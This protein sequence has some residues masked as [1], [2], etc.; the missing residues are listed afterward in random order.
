MTP[1]D[2]HARITTLFHDALEQPAAERL[3]WLERTCPDTDLRTAVTAMLAAHGGDDGF[4][5]Q[6]FL[7]RTETGA[8]TE[9]PPDVRIQG[10]PIGP[11][12]IEER[13]G[14]GGMGVVYRASRADGLYERTV[15]LKL[16]APGTILASG[17]P[18]ARRLAAERQIL[19][20][21]EH[22]GIARL[23]DG[24]VTE[25]GLPY[26]ALELVDGEPITDYA[27]RHDLNAAQRVDLFAQA[28][29]A[30]AYA[31]RNLV[32]HR[33]L[34]P[35]HILIAE[36]AVGREAI[37]KLLDFGVSALL[38][39][40]TGD[41]LT[42]PT[43][44]RALTPS[45]A[46]PEQV[47]GEPVTTA[48]D[49]YALGV[50]LYELLT[51]QRPYDLSGKTAS[52]VERLVAEV[53]PP[54][55]STVASPERARTLRGDLDTIVMKALAKEPERRYA[56]AEALAL[57]L[58][59]HLRGLPVE[60][61]PATARY[62]LSR[63]VRRHRVGVAATAAVVL[64]TATLIGFYTARLAAERD[65]TA[66]ALLRAEGTLAF[67]EETILSGDPQQGDF[68]APLSAVL[69]SAAARVEAIEDPAVAAAVGLALATVYIGRGLPEPA[70][71]HARE[72]FAFYD[73]EEEETGIPTTERGQALN[74]IA[75]AIRDQRRLEDALP[76]HAQAIAHLRRVEDGAFGLS[77]A[78]NNYGATLFK[79]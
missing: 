24:G 5:D 36:N 69:D 51:G 48:A 3:A 58:R 12:R 77:L 70:E 17:E 25:E 34:K 27:D 56:S 62:R 4:L 13:L 35:A 71:Q 38:G 53:E 52:E 45:Y 21:L 65:R 22:P 79:L 28:C 61:R 46:A 33:D 75:T 9:A 42:L 6:P 78:L 44:P 39:D 16:L 19:A 47:R 49:V 72:A 64:V 68:D 60:A 54:L 63:F 11:W 40:P 43:V 2:R 31:H 26:L 8:T 14:A 1:T 41:G 37:V 15:A 29:D 23:Y 67:L 18:L 20:R 30:V 55:P 74:Q 50:V 7:A 66:E 57:D 73:A 10:Q 76:Y 59:R 32:V